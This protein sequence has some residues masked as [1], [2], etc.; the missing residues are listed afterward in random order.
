[1]KCPGLYEGTPIS[2]HV[3]APCPKTYA[4]ALE[5][6]DLEAVKQDILYLLTHSQ[7]CWPADFGHYGPFFVRLAWHCSGTF[8]NTDGAGGCAGGR[9]RFEPEAS[10]MDNG[11][12]D[13]AR[14]LLAP[15]KLKYGIG[16]SWGDLFVLAGTTALRT[17]AFREWFENE[18][19][20]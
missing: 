3:D 15:I 6:L 11:N 17:I 5:K 4:Q 18:V 1:M 16:L 19:V 20:L 7:P 13:K 8:R 12:L 9:Q 14:A 2:P 10:W